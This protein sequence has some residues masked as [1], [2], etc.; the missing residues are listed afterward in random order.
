M[1]ARSLFIALATGSWLLCAA[2]AS[3]QLLNLDT[4]DG[5]IEIDASEA[6]E[7]HSESQQYIARGNARVQQGPN[8]VRA[9]VLTADY[10][11]GDDG[12]TEIYRLTA[13]G[14]VEIDAEETQIRG[15]RAVYNLT[16]ETF[17]LTG[18]N[19][20]LTSDQDRV[21]AN[22]L[23]YNQRTGVAVARGNAVVEREGQQ[24]EADTITAYVVSGSSGDQELDRVL[25]QGNVRVTSPDGIATAEE[26]VYDAVNNVATL[27]GSVR[28]T[29]GQN[30]L[31]GDIAEV[32][33][34]TGVSRL[35]SQSEGEGLVRGLLVPEED[36]TE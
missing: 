9:E 34:D 18:S 6:L 35:L 31:A 15:D 28:I 32:N 27:T 24:I 23:E 19:V 26:G 1:M 20:S 2:S 22:S 17:T 25:A 36:A 12:N 14:G 33:L 11:E 10:R 8:E 7:W 3:A 21:T 16:D 29:R 30:Q 4:G 13:E 5:P